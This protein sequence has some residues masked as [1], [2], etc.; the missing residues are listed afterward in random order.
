MENLIA[1]QI[2][3]SRHCNCGSLQPNLHLLQCPSYVMHD[4]TTVFFQSPR[5]PNISWQ[6]NTGG[7]QVQHQPGPC[8]KGQ[9]VYAEQQSKIL[10]ELSCAFQDTKQNPWLLLLDMSNSLFVQHDH[11]EFLTLS[12]MPRS[13]NLVIGGTKIF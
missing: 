8:G 2:F 3:D 12:H 9:L 7:L 11:Q 5:E 4:L 6:I 1:A 10:L 13:R